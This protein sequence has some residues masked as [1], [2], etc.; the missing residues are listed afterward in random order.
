MRLQQK[1]EAQT[2]TNQRVVID[3]RWSE[4]QVWLSLD[5]SFYDDGT[6]LHCAALLRQARSANREDVSSDA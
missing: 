1:L 5:V 3:E 2:A 6:R 4:D